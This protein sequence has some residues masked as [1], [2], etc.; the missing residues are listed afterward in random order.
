V[1]LISK[2]K[3]QDGITETSLISFKQFWKL[4]NKYPKISFTQSID[5]AK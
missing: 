2:D 4:Y 1:C 3:A 5:F